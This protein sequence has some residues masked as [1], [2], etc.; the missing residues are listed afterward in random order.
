MK[1]F[2]AAVV[3]MFT[4]GLCFAKD[5]ENSRKTGI[6][7][8]FGDMIG[9]SNDYSAYL[10]S[11]DFAFGS[12]KSDEDGLFDI[13]QSFLLGFN[14]GNISNN[15]MKYRYPDTNIVFT[16]DTK[17]HNIFLKDSIG[18]QA[19]ILCFSFGAMIGTKTGVEWLKSYGNA[20]SFDYS[21]CLKEFNIYADFVPNI[22]C[23]LN[24]FKFIKSALMVDCELPFVKC[25]FISDKFEKNGE[26]FQA[27][28]PYVDFNWFEGDIPFTYSAGVTLFF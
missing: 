26:T 23:S 17:Y 11:F 12:W 19:N 7:V 4:A 6:S 21:Y 8:L 24:L 2:F 16:Q 15:G 22:Y 1:K 9:Y 27:Y 5:D 20:Q 25:R 10:N 3:L 28:A 18:V 14:K 13:T